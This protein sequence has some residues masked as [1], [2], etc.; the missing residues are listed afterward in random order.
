MHIRSIGFIFGVRGLEL[1]KW[2]ALIRD[3]FINNIL[4]NMTIIPQSEVV[5][6]KCMAHPENLRWRAQIS[7]PKLWIIHCTRGALL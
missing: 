7:S 1:D 6:F 4:D 5:V 3:F 2:N